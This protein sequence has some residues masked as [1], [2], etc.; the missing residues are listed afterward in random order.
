[1]TAL[2]RLQDAIT[3]LEQLKAES[4]PGPWQVRDELWDG[5]GRWEIEDSAGF[6]VSCDGDGIGSFSEP[7]T[8]E[9]I[10]T[11]HT[12]LPAVLGWMREQLFRMERD[13]EAVTDESRAIHYRHVLA[14][15]DSI[16]DGEQ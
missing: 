5:A 3:K 6:S 1:M 8:P 14:V 13:V 12:M 2:Q 16:L 10:V 9:L 7:L 15:A 4:T 11:L